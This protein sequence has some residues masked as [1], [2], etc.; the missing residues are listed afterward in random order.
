MGVM[1]F[2]GRSLLRVVAPRRAAAAAAV[3]REVDPQ[4]V[5]R[6]RLVYEPRADA[7]PDGGEI[8]WTW[9]PY[10]E[11]DGRGK[12]RPVLVVARHGRDRFYAV[13]LTSK[14]HASET[15]YVS[16]GAGAWDPQRRPSWVDADQLYSVH[17]QGLRREGSAL[18]RT[19][20]ERVATVL[21][22]RYGWR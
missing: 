19:R 21:R 6:L 12:D 3:T 7:L 9:V 22:A 20:F 10:A 15:G 16:I 14:P 18:D 8:V 11:R 5:A 2:L 1:S 4:A 13:K 17:R